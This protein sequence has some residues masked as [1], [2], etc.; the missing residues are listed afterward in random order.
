VTV[1]HRCPPEHRHAASS[2]C[3]K[4]H[5]C[6]CL[7][8]RAANADRAAQR[9]KHH[10]YGRPAPRVPAGPT[11]THLAVLSDAGIGMRRVSELT[12]LSRTT[13]QTILRGR[14]GNGPRARE[15]WKTVGRDV[16]TKILAL[17]PDAETAAPSAMVPA[18]G[19]HRRVQAL[20]AA[21]WSVAAL[22]AK[23]E[24][25][26]SNLWT[27]LGQDQITAAMH[28][29]I[30]Q[31]HDGFATCPPP[32]STPHERAAA[33]RARRYAAKRGWQP[34]LAWDDI[35]H[36]PAPPAADDDAVDELA[37]DLWLEGATGALN[38][39]DWPTAVQRATD[40]GWTAATIGE[41]LGCT[42]RT[43]VRIRAQL[44]GTAA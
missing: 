40:L 13:L 12:G 1:A 28:H 3:Y 17:T 23:V 20:V 15:H 10:A 34:S 36:D 6:R 18:T 31:L 43:V 14:G 32:E 44:S 9:A 37:V 27:V 42:D 39:L 29:R 7:P 5:D 8:C 35:D 24:M 4:Q 22:A 11:R 33:T 26:T 38:R 2:T 21:G 19:A 30:V 25:E 41:R 16:E